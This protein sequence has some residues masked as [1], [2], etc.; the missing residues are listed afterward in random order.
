ME[1]L[2]GI[3]ITRVACGYHHNMALTGNSFIFLLLFC[4]DFFVLFDSDNGKVFVW[5]LNNCGQL[6]TN[7]TQ[8]EMIP[9]ELNALNEHHITAIACGY[10]H[11]LALTG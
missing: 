2:R 11:S 4:S 8:N 3:N 9:V 6:G 5:G 1:K 7:N 10:N